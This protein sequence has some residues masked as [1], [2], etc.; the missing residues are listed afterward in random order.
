MHGPQNVKF[1]IVVTVNHE[2]A[3]PAV[4]NLANHCTQPK[5]L[6]GGGDFLQRVK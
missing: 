2:H 5:D 3:L 6:A 1:V 4:K